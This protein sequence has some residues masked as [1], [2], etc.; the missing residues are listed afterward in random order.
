MNVAH[1]PDDARRRADGAP[2]LRSPLSAAL[3]SLVIVARH[4]GLHLS[5]PQLVKRHAPQTSAP[6]AKQLLAI[7]RQEGLRGVVVK[8]RFR[9]VLRLNHALPA[10]VMMRHSS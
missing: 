5:E 4:R 1:R 9:N 2:E 8:M 10:L 6:T 7:A 3:R